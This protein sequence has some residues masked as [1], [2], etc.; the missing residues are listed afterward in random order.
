MAHFA[1][2]MGN[3]VQTVIVIP[4]DQLL[5]A[6]GKESEQL[7]KE[8]CSRLFNLPADLYVQCSYNAA[9]NGFRGCYPGQGYTWDGSV[10][11]PPVIVE[12]S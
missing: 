3:T 5:D 10:F 1:L 6:N 2:V 11:S 8:Y 4:N 7:G 9:M 12:P